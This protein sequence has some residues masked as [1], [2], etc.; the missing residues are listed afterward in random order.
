MELITLWFIWPVLSVLYTSVITSLFVVFLLIFSIFQ[1]L[2][3]NFQMYTRDC[4]PMCHFDGRDNE[5]LRQY[6]EPL[7]SDSALYSFSGKAAKCSENKAM[8]LW[9]KRKR[10]G[11]KSISFIWETYLT[12]PDLLTPTITPVFESHHLLHYTHRLRYNP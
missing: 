12:K 8:S 2:L 6:N 1:V 7:H 9:H 10:G 5:I 3:C 4:V 11:K